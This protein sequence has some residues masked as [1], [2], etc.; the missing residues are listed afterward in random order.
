MN[1]ELTLRKETEFDIAEHFGFYEGKRGGLG[2]VF[3][4]RLL[5]LSMADSPI[6]P[7]LSSAGL[8]RTSQGLWPYHHQAK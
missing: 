7:F 6:I 2:Q 8:E 1:Y 5:C 3:L 4:L